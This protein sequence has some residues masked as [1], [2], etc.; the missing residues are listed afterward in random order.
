MYVAECYELGIA[1]QGYSIEEAINN[2]KEA[3]ELYLENPTLINLEEIKESPII[4][5]FVAKIA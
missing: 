2:L 1:S 4:A 5:H 3:A